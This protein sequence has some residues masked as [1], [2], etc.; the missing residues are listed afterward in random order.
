MSEPRANGSKNVPKAFISY[1]HDFPAHSDRVLAFAVA[2]RNHGIDV[3][4]DQFHTDEITTLPAGRVR[5]SVHQ[6]RQRVR[7]I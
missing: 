5:R 1:S 7:N 6:I 2:L 4:L 3:E